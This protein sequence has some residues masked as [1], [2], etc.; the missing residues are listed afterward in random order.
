MLPRT[1]AWLGSCLCLGIAQAQTDLDSIVV[2]ASRIAEPRADVLAS[3]LVIEPETIELDQAR[4]VAELLRFHAGLEIARNG[5]PGQPASLFLRGTESNHS[6]ILLNGIPINPG[7][8]GLTALQDISPEIVDRIEVVKGPRSVLY[9]S[10][11][12]GGVVN[13]FTKSPRPDA[14]PRLDLGLAAGGDGTA[15]ANAYWQDRLGNLYGGI[16]AVGFTSDGFPPRV[17]SHLDRGQDLKNLMAFGGYDLGSGEVELRHWESRGRTQYLD[18]SLAPLDQDVRHG[19]TS[20]SLHQS[21]VPGWDSR[22]GVSYFVDSIKQNQSADYLETR[23]W[24]W[25]WQNHFQFFP[26]H[27][28]VVGVL[29]NQ[30]RTASLSYGTGYDESSQDIELFLQDDIRLEAQHFAMGVGLV[31]NGQFG[32]QATWNL[33]YGYRLEPE[34]WLFASA[35]TAFRAPD[36]TD[37]YGFGGNPQLQPERSRSLEAG[38]RHSFRPGLEGNLTLYQTRIRDLIEFTDPDGFLGPQPGINRN[39]AAARI[40]G[41]EIAMEYQRSP[42]QLGVDLMW[43]DPRDDQGQQLPRRSRESL[44]ARLAYRQGRYEIGLN[45]LAT[46]KRLDSTFNPVWLPGY[47]LFA[48]GARLRLSPSWSLGVKIDNLFDTHYE[49]ADGYR[50]QGRLLL[51]SID[52]NA[53]R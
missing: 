13:I 31:H 5:G 53:W 4:D 27:D 40:E 41:L 19:L 33:G 48:L 7:T 23:R 14:P 51:F 29:G 22:I 34:T 46:G 49:M 36:S 30:E 39:I 12:I 15:Q 21:P 18:F 44:A 17:E 28:L 26:K 47:T 50:S 35:G 11:A 38:I 9:G 3:S 42:W 37:L 52:Y 43:Q 25:D 45:A 32:R 10:R 20:L 6:L 16:G 24:H 2:T 1:T 8:I